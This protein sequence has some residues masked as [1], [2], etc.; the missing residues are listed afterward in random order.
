[1]SRKGVM[2]QDCLTAALP[3]VS[4]S[5]CLLSRFLAYNGNGRFSLADTL[6]T[7]RVLSSIFRDGELGCESA[8][9]TDAEQLATVHCTSTQH[10]AGG[11]VPATATANLLAAERLRKKR[12]RAEETTVERAAWLQSY[13]PFCTRCSSKAY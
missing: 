8:D 3:I 11:S 9:D 12:H 7:S 2:C 4:P 6:C 13:V 5:I 10:S 1:M